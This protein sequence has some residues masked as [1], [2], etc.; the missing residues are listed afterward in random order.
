MSKYRT[1]VGIDYADKR[2]EAGQIVSDIPDAAV[3]WLRESGFIEGVAE[4]TKDQ[5]D[6]VTEKADDAPQ[7]AKKTVA[8]KTARKAGA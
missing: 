1:V 5:H 7:A 6:P 8:K 3:G 2:V 4:P